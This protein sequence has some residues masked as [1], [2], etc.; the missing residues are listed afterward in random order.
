MQQLSGLDTTFLRMETRNVY[1]H[2]MGLHVFETTPR[3]RLTVETV[4]QLIRD[5]LHLAPPLTRRLVEVP[6]GVNNPYWI[7][8]PDFDLEYHVREIAL[9]APG[10]NAQLQEQVARIASRHLDRRRPLWE[11][12]V[13]EGLEDGATAMLCKFHH[14][15]VDGVAGAELMSL[16]L[17]PDPEGAAVVPAPGPRQPE[18]VPTELDVL[19]LAAADLLRRPR[20]AVRFART[21]LGRVAQAAWRG[22]V[23][24]VPGLPQLPVVGRLLQT[25]RQTELSRPDTS[26]P[27][28][29][30]GGPVSPHRRVSLST[31]SLADVK[32]VKDRT[33]STV[34]DVV[35]A[36]CAGGLRRWLDKAGELP[37]EPLHAAVPV[38]VRTAEEM[39]TWGNRV[40]TMV[41]AL[42]TDVDD[43]L[44][45]LTLSSEAMVIAKDEHGAVPATLL[46]DVTQFVP[47]FMTG[48]AFRA[49]ATS[50]IANRVQM[51]FNVLVSN[52]PGPRTPV[53]LDGIRQR[54]Y[55][56]VSLVADGGRLNITVVSYVDQL[57]L[58]LV[59]DRDLPLD[60]DELAEHMRSELEDLLAATA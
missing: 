57:H 25:Q 30:L 3:K 38:S 59:A 4:R 56:P 28:T 12:Y 11:T 10:T 26:P 60:L 40:S 20:R 45:R 50:A 53:Y 17:D 41:A 49:L 55:H 43:P 23:L 34:N 58:G 16:L 19:A 5:R 9:P 15:A 32:T 31:L 33:G 52:V 42:P 8:D 2:V 54:S 14:A 37:P 1:G 47:P 21:S 7:E 51:P 18:P 48:L 6:L 46:Q 27:R 29:V 24:G 36:L 44:T 39:G 13:I 22:P 35:M